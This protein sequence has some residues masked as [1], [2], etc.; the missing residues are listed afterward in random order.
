MGANNQIDYIEFQAVGP[1]GDAILFR[2]VV[3]LEI[4]RLRPGLYFLRRWKDR[5][6][7]RARERRSTI[8]SGGVWVVFYHPRLEEVRQRDRDLD[9]KV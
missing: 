5:R 9:G 3:R 6:W 1:S 4:H 7:L 8:E 2:A